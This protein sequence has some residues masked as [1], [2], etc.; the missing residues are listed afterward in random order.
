MVIGT[1]YNQIVSTLE[2]NPTLKDY[3]KQ[4]FRGYRYNIAK[5]SYPCLMAEIVRNNEIEKD[6][7]QIKRIWGELD[8]LGF[9]MEHDNESL[10]VG[11]PRKEIYGIL[12][13]ENDI[14]ACLQSS[15]TLGGKAIDL[16]MQPTEFDYTFWPV[17]GLRIRARVLY[18]QED[19]V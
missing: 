5:D 17:R 13:I 16:Q 4:V 11:D 12:N 14:R 7:G 1:I 19:G 2:N 9:V 10:I 8:I 18:Q 3:I 15:N 6:F